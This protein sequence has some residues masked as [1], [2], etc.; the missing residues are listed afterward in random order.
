MSEFKLIPPHKARGYIVRWPKCQDSCNYR[1]S[2]D[3]WI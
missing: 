2:Y 1:R 3:E